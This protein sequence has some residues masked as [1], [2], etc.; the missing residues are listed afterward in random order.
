MCIYIFG[1]GVFVNLPVHANISLS[2]FLFNATEEGDVL[3][4]S[5]YCTHIFH[6]DCILEW[7]DKHDE[8][9]VCRVDMVTE[10]EIN[11][12]ATSL[13]GKTRMCKAVASLSSAPLLRTSPPH[14][15]PPAS[16]GPR[17]PH[18][19]TNTV[20]RMGNSQR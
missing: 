13:V 8:C 16:P 20:R 11:K 10:G 6:K 17:G 2:S 4:A 15:T 9:P 18:T 14:R 1:H 3:I 12:A 19:P 5:K 7:L